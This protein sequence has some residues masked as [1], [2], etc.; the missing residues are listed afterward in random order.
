V[1]AVVASLAVLF[2]VS[3][4]AGCAGAPSPALEGREFLST[5][6]S[7]NGAAKALVPGTQV[8]ISFRDGGAHASAGCNSMSGGYVLANGRLVVDS[9]GMT[10]MGCDPP[11]HAQ[12]QWLAAFL[13]SR[14]AV[15]LTGNDLL[16]QG[17]GIAMRLVDRRVA[18][19]D[20]P[21]VG[22]F[23]TVE[24]LIV[25]DGVSTVPAGVVAT[26][27]LRP[28][29]GFDVATG[30][31]QGS[32]R[33]T[34]AGDSL[35]F[36]DLGLTRMACQGAAGQVE[37]HFLRILGADAVAFELESQTLTLQSGEFGLVLRGQ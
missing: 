25:F 7:E 31:N 20:L 1:R 10:E 11:R 36:T 35:R 34:V 2:A 12:D 4:L 18:E 9:L 26:L 29:G 32:G 19:P 37:T 30:C 24:A 5:A 17:G 23:W 3:V 15:E 14:P 27:Q 28:D 6:V 13:T 33:V 8:R 22:T 21:L 16:L